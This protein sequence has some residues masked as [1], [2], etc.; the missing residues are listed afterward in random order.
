MKAAI[1]L[2]NELKA[3]DVK[4]S[5]NDLVL[6]AV[7]NALVK[8]PNMNATFHGDSI[9]KYH[10]AHVA[11]AVAADGVLMTPVVR[12]ADRKSLGQ[13][14]AE[15]RDLIER[16]R[17]RKLAQEEYTGGTF[18]ISNLGMYGVSEFTGIINAPAVGLLAVGGIR[19]EPVVEGGASNHDAALPAGPWLG[20]RREPELQEM[21]DDRADLAAAGIALVLAQVLDL[22]REPAGVDREILP[23]GRE[24]AQG[25]GLLPR[26]GVE[27]RVV[28]IVRELAH[29][30]PLSSGMIAEAAVARHRARGANA[31]FVRR[32]TQPPF[33][34]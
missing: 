32:L 24:L 25:R 31:V 4:F 8:V 11:F 30:P 9:T 1:A 15:T 14:A 16:A 27:I 5:F 13:V 26:P 29:R 6:K 12:D 3:H 10:V 18:T 21:L 28:E 2:R 23:L 20:G 34:A 19:D 17:T 33:D 22:L 7:A